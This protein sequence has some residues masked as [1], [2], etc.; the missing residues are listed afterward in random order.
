MLSLIHTCSVARN[1]TTGTNGRRALSSL[2]TG[3]A[4]LALPMTARAEVQNGFDL[5]RGYDFYFAPGTDIKVKDRLTFSGKTY[6]VG[7]V[8]EFSVPTVGHLHI[9]AQQEVTT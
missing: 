1:Q 7:G 8:Q 2:Y 4:C 6:T 3:I 9:V 5:G